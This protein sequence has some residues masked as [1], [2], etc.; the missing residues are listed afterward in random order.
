MHAMCIEQAIVLAG[1]VTLVNED[2]VTL[3][4]YNSTTESGGPIDTPLADVFPGMCTVCDPLYL[5]EFCEYEDGYCVKLSDDSVS[6]IAMN[7]SLLY[8]SPY[9]L[10]SECTPWYPHRLDQMTYGI[11]CRESSYH[12]LRF[13]EDG[14]VLERNMQGSGSGGILVPSPSGELYHVELK[15]SILV[16]YGT[17]SS[18]PQYRFI[19]SSCVSSLKIRPTFTSSGLFHLSCATNSGSQVHLLYSANNGDYE[20]QLALCGDPLFSPPTS[21]PGIDTFAVACGKTITVYETNNV[22]E[23]YSMSFNSTILAHSYLDKGMLLVDTGTKQHVV[24]VD[25][26]VNSSGS[27]GIATLENT[28]N[29]SLLK[30]ALTPDIFSTV[31]NNGLYYSVR[32]FD[33][34]RRPELSPIANLTK[35]PKDIYFE[36]QVLEVPLPPSSDH[37]TAVPSTPNNSLIQTPLVHTLGTK[38]TNSAVSTPT[39]SPTP[40]HSL[41]VRYIISACAV[42]LAIAVFPLAAFLLFLWRWRHGRKARS[43]D[44]SSRTHHPVQVVDKQG[45]YMLEISNLGTSNHAPTESISSGY[46]SY[47][48]GLNVVHP[49][50]ETHQDT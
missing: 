7:G 21:S 23:S 22:A 40:T 14:P 31:C 27:D 47:T 50:P 6:I 36:E 46:D 30:K 2:S 24:A 19:N 10:D 32:L 48:S 34:N 9:M 8:S 39:N 42:I 49:V 45:T 28:L 33:I 44:F 16:V 25:T 1:A 37:P 18:H 11:V 13:G 20:H 43:C 5:T 29:C 12:I 41:A 35:Q 3:Q 26:F 15:D 17:K 4:L 38:T